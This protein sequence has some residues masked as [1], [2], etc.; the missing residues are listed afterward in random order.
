MREIIYLDK[1][2][3]PNT[4][5]KTIDEINSYYDS[6]KNKNV[7]FVKLALIP[8]ILNSYN[9]YPFSLTYLVQCYIRCLTRDTHE[10]LKNED[11]YHLASV[12]FKFFKFYLR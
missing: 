9:E 7:K 12:L 5:G 2:H 8:E 1:N 4:I 3:P 10:T 11:P 6:I